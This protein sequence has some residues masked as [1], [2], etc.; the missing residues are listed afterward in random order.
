[1]TL[2]GRMKVTKQQLYTIGAAVLFLL[3]SIFMILYTF[4]DLPWAFWTGLGIAIAAAVVY[5]LLVIENRSIISKK[6]T[7]TSYPDKKARINEHETK[8]SKN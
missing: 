7:D 6:L 4:M 2:G 1:M 3:G 5:V 8:T